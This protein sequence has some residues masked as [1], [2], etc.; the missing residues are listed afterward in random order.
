MSQIAYVFPGQGSQAPGMGAPWERTPAWRLVERASL[1]SG[2]DVAGL[3]LHADADTLRRTDNAQL[4][5]FVLSSVVHAEVR[6]ALPVPAP[7]AVAGHSLGEYSALVA[8]GALSFDDGVRLVVARG[9]AMR[10]A[11]AA[12]PGT[13][14][15]VLGLDART[16][17]DLTASLRRDG[18]RVWVANL[19]S[20][21]QSVVSGTPEGVAR[22]ARAA[23]DEGAT[24]VVD[25]PVGGA[26]HSPLMASAEERLRRALDGVALRP[27]TVPVVANVDAEPHT[28][29]GRWPGLVLDQLTSPV[30]W[31]DGVRTLTGRLG[32]D[33]LVELGPGRVL[34]GFTRR[35]SPGTGRAS[36]AVPDD[37]PAL[38][39]AVGAAR[40][41][42][43][44]VGAAA[45]GAA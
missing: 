32:A 7:V 9:E 22:C 21:L 12:A 31:L 13:M 43:A 34:T 17:L 37:V 19:N 25:I 29:P 14:G 30:R 40:E 4:A 3:L 36:V 11:C 28:D 15:V 2:R 18:A 10:E 39:S 20:A 24:R 38:A 5:T 6:E 27:A 44:T 35:I 16:V 26:F 8:S 41:D 1:V 42:G 33:L 45:P 23:L